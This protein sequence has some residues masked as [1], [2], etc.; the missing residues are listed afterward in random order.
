MIRNRGTWNIRIIRSIVLAAALIGCAANPVYYSATLNQ[1]DGLGPGDIV[2]HDGN[3]IGTV[4]SIS[5]GGGDVQIS[6]QLEHEYG[7]VIREDSMLILQG[8]GTTPSLELMTPDTESPRVGEGALLYGASNESQAQMFTSMLGPPAIANT[9]T[10][11]FNRYAPSSQPTPAPGSSVMQNQLM[12]ILRQ[13]IAATT[14]ISTTTQAGRAQMDQFREDA[15]AVAR[16]LQ[17]HGKTAE[18][19]QLRA[20]IAQMNAATPPVRGPGP[21]TL[22]VPPASPVP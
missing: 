20:Q 1:P 13:T 21:N 3:P 6:V 11:F 19:A 18:A 12:D 5:S 9:Y 16:Q 22:T 8:A 14:A 15:S 2:R 4:T 17:V 10:Q 7:S